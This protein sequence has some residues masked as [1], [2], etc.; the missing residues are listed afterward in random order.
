MNELPHK[1][2]PTRMFLSYVR[3]DD[4]EPYDTSTSFVAR[5]HVD[6][7]SAGF[8]VWFDRVSMP[9]R[10]FPFHDEVA[11]AIRA[12]DRLVMMVGPQA[13]S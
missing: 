4:G 1:T 7:S 11:D 13:A 6:P 8:G 2:S 3:A 9:S 12:R 5:L 10:Q